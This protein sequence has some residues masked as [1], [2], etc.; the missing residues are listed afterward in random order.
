MLRNLSIRVR[1]A[2]IVIIGAL[3]LGVVAM[4]ELVTLRDS[5]M[6]ERQEGIRNLVSAS[7]STIAGLDAAASAAGLDPAAAQALAR[8]TLRATRYG[9]T[10]SDYFF[11]FDR[12][13][14]MV[15]HPFAPTLEGT[16]LASFADPNGVLLFRDMLTAAEAGGGYV[17]YQWARGDSDVLLPKIS[18]AALYEPWGWAVGSGVYVDDVD[19]AFWRK[20]E[21]AGLLVAVVLL[22]T[23]GV[24]VLVSSS[25]ARPIVRI[26]RVMDV[27]AGG[28]TDV[29]VPFAAQ[30]DEIGGMARAVEVFRVG[31]EEKAAVEASRQAAER[32][33]EADRRSAMESFAGE[34]E[35][36]VG[37]V[38]GHVSAA[39]T[40][41]Q[42]TAEAMSG[43]ANE[44][45]AQATAL[46]AAA[47]AAS[48]NVGSVAAASE[49]LTGSIAEIGRQMAAQSEA[50][51][52]AAGAAEE[53]DRR[54]K[55]LSAKVQDIGGV[56]GLITEIADQTN[57][58][59]LNA[60]IEAARAGEAGRGFAVVAAEVKALASQTASATSRIAAQIQGVQEETEGSVG[61]MTEIAQCITHV[62][63]IA[64][65]V[66][67]AVEQQDAA[68]GEIGR[69]A[70]GAAGSTQSVADAVSGLTDVSRRT[71]ETAET[72]L[73]AAGQLTSDA[74]DLSQEVAD[75][76]K[77]VRSG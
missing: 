14:N 76:V 74:G 17:P 43:L 73:G 13:L 64:T 37:N 51:A 9:Q 25:I 12:D 63:E 23:G 49:Q 3:G 15:M 59:A 31:I 67:A 11:V 66:A 20:V 53:S 34:F 71:G 77:R 60:T 47:Q 18:Y 32:Q 45:Q 16:S 10:Q 52:A 8:E 57:L 48:T 2:L 22:L 26:A 70:Q 6:R 33:A 27:M 75:F 4:A 21:R 39:A 65:S 56:V 72:V 7:I 29:Q 55:G 1:L 19:T 54:V 5:M 68:A 30:R 69:S 50:A 61:A 46:E 38:V 58:L 62:R 41:M 40:D 36:S 44:T 42:T 24:A 35:S 28:R